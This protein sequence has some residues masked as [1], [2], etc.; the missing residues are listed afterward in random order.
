MIVSE[1]LKDLAEEK[2]CRA[3]CKHL[4]D[5]SISAPYAKDFE[6][7]PATV[8]GPG[9]EVRFDVMTAPLAFVLRQSDPFELRMD[10]VKAEARKVR[11]H[12]S[13]EAAQ[14][15]HSCNTDPVEDLYEAIGY[16]AALEIQREIRV[17]AYDWTHPDTGEHHK[18]NP[19]QVYALYMPPHMTPSYLDPKDFS[20]R[21]G[22]R[23]RYAKVYERPLA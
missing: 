19:V 6:S 9:H 21:R 16:D 5:W 15:L 8:F 10:L 22:F 20:V 23:M 3:M 2:I 18:G 7:N 4:N 17:A 12:W 11:V 13:P 14:D 1:P